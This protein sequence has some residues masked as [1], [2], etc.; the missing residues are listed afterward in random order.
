MTATCQQYGEQ[1]SYTD[2]IDARRPTS[3]HHVAAL[4]ERIAVLEALVAELQ[5]QLPAGSQQQP[6]ISVVAPDVKPFISDYL[7]PAHNQDNRQGKPI[8]RSLSNDQDYSSLLYDVGLDR[9][10]VDQ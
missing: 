4:Q 9:L 8:R 6:R 2:G 10:K 5:A 3:K 7:R 1:C